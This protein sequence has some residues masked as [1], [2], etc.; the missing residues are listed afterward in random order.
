MKEM[1]IHNENELEK[2]RQEIKNFKKLSREIPNIIT[3]YDSCILY[4]D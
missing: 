3:F 1:V 2:A 4:K